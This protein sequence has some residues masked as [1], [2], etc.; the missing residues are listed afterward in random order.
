VI[1]SDAR[2][3]IKIRFNPIDETRPALQVD[4]SVRDVFGHV[5][6]RD[7]GKSLGSNL[8]VMDCELKAWLSVKKPTDSSLQFV[9]VSAVVYA[10]DA[11]KDPVKR[12]A[13]VQPL[14]PRKKRKLEELR[15]NGACKAPE[16]VDIRDDGDTDEDDTEPSVMQTQPYVM[17]ECPF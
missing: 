3:G 5:I 15:R 10:M 16:V 12:I 17:D 1:G 13:E 6:K 4:L 9:G 7:N 11:P 14:S 2:S 8:F